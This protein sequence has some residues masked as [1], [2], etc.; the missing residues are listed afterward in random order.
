[1]PDDGIRIDVLKETPLLPAPLAVRVT[2][3]RLDRFTREH[4]DPPVIDLYNG[5]RPVQPPGSGT[6]TAACDAGRC[7]LQTD[8][9]S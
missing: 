4:P 3:L 5:D 9:F 2:E 6:S 1:M 7:R 8:S